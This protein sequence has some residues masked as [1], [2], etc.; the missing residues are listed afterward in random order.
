[1]RYIVSPA[2]KKSLVERQ[3]FTKDGKSITEVC[4]WR[5]GSFACESDE[6]PVINEGDDLYCTDYDLELLECWDG[7]TEY[8]FEGF[9]E[10]EQAEMESWLEENSL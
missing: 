10:D 4:V 2:Y 7:D 6:P 3:I 9:S 1:M 5:S 8:L